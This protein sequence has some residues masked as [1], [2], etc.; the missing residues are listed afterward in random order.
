MA[1][2]A[3]DLKK[4]ADLI[5][6][7]TKPLSDSVTEIKTGYAALD[8]KIADTAKL[9]EAAKAKAEPKPGEPDEVATRLATLTAQM[10]AAEQRAQKAE[11]DR[12]KSALDVQMGEALAKAG[13]PADKVPHAKAWLQARGEITF[14]DATGMPRMKGKI[15]GVPQMV[16]LDAGISAW[17]KTDE[18]KHYLPPVKAD[19]GTGEHGEVRATPLTSTGEPDWSAIG[20]RVVA[21]RIN[22]SH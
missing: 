12:R 22:L 7:G 10:E 14:D 18:A 11:A 4:I 16:D 15:A 13:V 21:P 20:A 17:G 5:A 6:A 19:G 8:G 9:I 3:D 1:L 2:D